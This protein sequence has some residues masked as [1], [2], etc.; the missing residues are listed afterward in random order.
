M[1]RRHQAPVVSGGLRDMKVLKTT[2]S[3]FVNFIDDEYRTLPDMNDRVFC[4]VVD[5]RWTYVSSGGAR[6][7][8]YDATWATVQ[9][10][11]L[12]AF[13]GDAR[14]GVAS[15]SVQKTLYDAAQLVFTRLQHVSDVTIELPNVHA[16]EFD[17]S[18]FKTLRLT[19]QGEVFQPTDK[20]SGNIKATLRRTMAKL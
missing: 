20:P 18:R 2:K 3:A 10:S 4:T 19:N 16:Y 15:P 11:I 5:A 8:D 6:I 7:I 1:H 9:R 17:Y 13:A 14:R 12:E